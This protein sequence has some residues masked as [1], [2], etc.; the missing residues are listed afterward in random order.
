[1]RLDLGDVERLADVVERAGAHGFDRRL[2]RAEAADEQYLAVG[3]LDLERAQQI[4][5]RLRGVEVDVGDHQVDAFLTQQPQGARR[6]LLGDDTT[7]LR[8]DE[9]GDEAAGFAIVIDDQNGMHDEPIS[10][11]PDPKTPASPRSAEVDGEDRSSAVTVRGVNLAALS[12]QHLAHDGEPQTRPAPDR[13]GRHPGFEE[14]RQ[15][16]GRDPGTGVGHLQPD[17][18]LRGSAAD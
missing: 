15:Q 7:A 12:R 8:G 13:L 2:E 4:E 3:V 1:M 16:I 6:V 5:A 9:L 11:L 17:A 10:A 14:V 18:L